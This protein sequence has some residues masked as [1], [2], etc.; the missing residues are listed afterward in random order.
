MSPDDL[1][2]TAFHEAGHALA[3][4][5]FGFP[6]ER[7][8][9]VP[10]GDNLGS[11]RLVNPNV[12][13][14]NLTK[15]IIYSLAGYMAEQRLL[16]TK[17]WVTGDEPD[18]RKAR[19]GYADLKQHGRVA[20]RTVPTLKE[21][22]ARTDALVW[23]H[24]KPISALAGRLISCGTLDGLTAHRILQHA[25]DQTADPTTLSRWWTTAVIKRLA[26]FLQPAPSPPP[27]H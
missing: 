1:I 3:A 25:I 24:R 7:V 22:Q 13:H 27:R 19:D 23:K 5:V 9:V 8:T 4:H 20:K 14:A 17:G 10:A 6:I 12:R 18:F 2:D 21:L 15:G 11:I 16:G 26:E